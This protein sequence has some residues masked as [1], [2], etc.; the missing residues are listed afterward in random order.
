ML[1]SL[2]VPQLMLPLQLQQ[3]RADLA[4]LCA[5]TRLYCVEAHYGEAWRA[6]FGTDE[7]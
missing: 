2:P 5:E 1:Q 3:V 7:V 6:N 4:N